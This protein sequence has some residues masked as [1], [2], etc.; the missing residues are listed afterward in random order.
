MLSETQFNHY[1]NTDIVNK[2][3]TQSIEKFGSG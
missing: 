3:K 1:S 2:E